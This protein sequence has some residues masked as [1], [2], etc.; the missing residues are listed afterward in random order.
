[1]IVCRYIWSF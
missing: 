1:M